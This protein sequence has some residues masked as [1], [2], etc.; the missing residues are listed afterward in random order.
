MCITIILPLILAILLVVQKDVATLLKMKCYGM[1][2]PRG[3][4]F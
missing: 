4:I 1:V 3:A 2:A